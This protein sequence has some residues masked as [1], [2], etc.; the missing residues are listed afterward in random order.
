MNHFWFTLSFLVAL[1]IAV[2]S[3]WAWQYLPERVPIHWNISGE[4]D[5][6]GS[7]NWRIVVGFLP[8][9]IWGLM[10]WI[11]RID[12]RRES[13][14]KHAKAYGIFTL[15]IIL[16]LSVISVITLLAALGYGVDVPKSMAWMIGL[17]LLVMGNYMGQIRPNFF[18]GI[19]TPW[20]L[21]SD[22]TWRK[23][24]RFGRIVFV[25]MGLL[26]ILAGFL[27]PQW[28]FAVVIASVVGG[29]GLTVVYSYLDYRKRSRT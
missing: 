13:F 7:R 14:L 11:P 17:L 29:T 2:T 22:E 4:V 24:H 1:G 15:M 18:V 3:L 8:L 9:L 12:P 28:A 16:T 20:T 10:A 5:K 27:K 23:T 26:T 6:Y 25:V 19:R 21:S